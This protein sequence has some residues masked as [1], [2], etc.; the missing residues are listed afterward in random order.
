MIQNVA[1]ILSRI[2]ILIV[3]FDSKYL[4]IFSLIAFE[5]YVQS[6]ASYPKH[7][8]EILPFKALHLGHIAKSFCLREAPSELGCRIPNAK[9]Q[10]KMMHLS[11]PM[12]YLKI[13][14]FYCAVFLNVC[15]ISCIVIWLY[16]YCW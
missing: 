15:I 11:K 4:H 8:R 3:K 14:S 16:N 7:I 2:F 10:K 12:R 9:Y 6:Y 13:K 5:S 1:S